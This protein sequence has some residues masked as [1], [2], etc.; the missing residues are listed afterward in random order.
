MVPSL[1]VKTEL[2]CSRILKKPL[3]NLAM[4]RK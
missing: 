2:K 3:E 4:D 1:K